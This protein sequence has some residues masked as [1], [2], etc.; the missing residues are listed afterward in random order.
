MPSTSI[1]ALDVA[2]QTGWAKWHN[3]VTSVGTVTFGKR[4]TPL[5]RVLARYRDWLVDQLD[6]GDFQAVAF[7]APYIGPHT[8]QATARV[9][10]GLAA[11][12]ELV[13][14]D[15]D[16][17]CLEANNSSVLLHFTGKGGGKRKDKKA[18]TIEAC[19]DR[20]FHPQNEDEADALGILDFTAHFLKV[21]TDI[22]E[23]PLFSERAA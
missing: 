6:G 21:K 4:G 16:V 13:C 15:H 1:L 18:R 9:L 7:E 5:V 8:H 12:T 2:T 20:G 11:V 23:G 22:P 14:D 10:L 19:N 3:Q 17:R